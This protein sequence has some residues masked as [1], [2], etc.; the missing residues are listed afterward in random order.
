M[1]KP[2]KTRNQRARQSPRPSAMSGGEVIPI[3]QP[4]SRQSVQWT[5]N[6]LRQVTLRADGGDLSLLADLCEQIIADDRFGELLGQLADDVLGCDLS[7][8]KDLRVIVG[9]AEKSDELTVDWARAYD[10]DELKSI[11]VWTL[12]TGIGFA[13]HEAW[14]ETAG[15]RIAP[16]LKWWHPQHFGFRTKDG[17]SPLT[18]SLKDHQWH[19]REGGTGKWL[20]IA[21]G[22]GTWVIVTRR[23]EYQPWRNGLWRGLGIWWLLKQYAMQDSGV[24][25]E[26]SAKTIVTTG[27]GSTLEDR[28][29]LANYIHSAG[30]DP[31]IALP[32]GA[33]LK[34]VEVQAN[35]E[36]LYHSQIRLAN[37]SAALTILGQNLSTNVEGGSLAAAKVH[38]AK[39]G[40]RVRNAAQMLSKGLCEQSISWWAEFNFGNPDLAP[41][42]RWHTEPATDYS[43]KAGVLQ[44]AATALLTLKT[45]GWEIDE[46]TVEE[47]LGLQL[48]KTKALVAREQAEP[49]DTDGDGIPHNEPGNVNPAKVGP[50]GV[51][52]DEVPSVEVKP[53]KREPPRPRPPKPPATPSPSAYLA[54]G[55]NPAEAKGFVQGQIYTDALTDRQVTLIAGELAPFVDRILK[56]INGA[57]DYDDVRYRVI[58]AFQN[59]SDPQQMASLIERSLLLAELA[60]R[61][62]VTEDMPEDD[63]A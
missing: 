15:G 47:E 27:E 46:A 61:N 3:S 44:Q 60:G 37:E 49:G 42:P 6:L 20:P 26:R 16:V 7:F 30:K 19:V 40:R 5:P 41:F 53:P 18:G 63:D 56:A 62:A 35:L 2:A 43:A 28:R 14:V 29:A 8:E 57:K 58:K 11:I 34:I 9:S 52:G 24:H 54:S 23:G 22:D 1:A 12:V 31:V 4:S 55:D 36:H 13:K 33:D 50:G 45:A 32:E 10:D 59:E 39:E 48:R 21:P 38:S 25:S 51:K 17:V